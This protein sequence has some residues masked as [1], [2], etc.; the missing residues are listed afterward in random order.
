MSTTTIGIHQLA[1]ELGVCEST[2]LKG[3]KKS[4][5]LYT[6]GFKIG[7][8]LNSPLRWFRDDVDNYINSKRQQAC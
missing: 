3:R 5:P 8:A 1:D 6:K 4:H 7:D 2:I